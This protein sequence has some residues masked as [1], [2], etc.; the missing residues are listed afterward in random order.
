MKIEELADATDLLLALD[1]DGTMAPIVD[2]PSAARSLSGFSEVLE[3]LVACPGVSVAVLTG[4]DQDGIR[5]LLSGFPPLWLGLSHGRDLLEPG[6]FSP[7]VAYDDPRLLEL[8]SLELPEGVRR[9]DKAHSC[10][11]HWRGRDQGRPDAWILH[12]TKFAELWGLNVLEGRMVIE[13]LLPGAGK[14]QALQEIQRR[15]GAKLVVFAGDDVT[16]LAAIAYAS[17]H[18]IGIHVRSTERAWE[19]PE[20]V[21]CVDGPAALLEWLRGLFRLRCRNG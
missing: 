19:A 12:L 20:G 17:R 11:F 7:P 8:R 2:E 18:G 14:L 16:D 3:K 21:L 4:R 13:V 6:T 9:E 15:S 5:P 10:A 1:F